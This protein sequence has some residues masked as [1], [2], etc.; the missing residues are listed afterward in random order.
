M[1][2]FIIVNKDKGISSF[3]VIREL[4][5]ILNIKKIGHTGTLDPIA[6]GILIICVGKATKLAQD[7]EAYKKTYIASMD[8]GYET[9]SYDTDGKIIN[10]SNIIVNRNCLE[11]VLKEYIGKINQV[12]PMYSAIKI[13]GEKLYNLARKGIE[14][15]RPTREVEA[16]NLELLEYDEIHKNAKILCEVAK[17]FYIRSLIFDLG[18]DTKMLATMT[19]LNRTTVLNY[20]LENSFSLN[21][22]KNLYF[23]NNL[24][25]LIKVEDFFDFEKI[26]LEKNEDLSKFKNGNKFKILKNYSEGLK[27]VYFNKEFIG[28]AQITNQYIKPYK[29]F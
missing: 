21:D 13:N 10:T 27:R 18:R 4:R 7:I 26:D 19:D 12:P 16:Y 8:F 5:K 23:E 9:D 14:I 20:S 2:G 3:D 22:I 17:G 25:F 11:K 6:T 29:Y 1:D 15:E 24:K 28:L